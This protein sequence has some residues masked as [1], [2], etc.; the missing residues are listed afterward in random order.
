LAPICLHGREE[1]IHDNF[2]MTLP[3]LAQQTLQAFCIYLP[4]PKTV[5]AKRRIVRK[6]LQANIFAY[7]AHYV[8]LPKI[9]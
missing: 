1:K 8:H 2:W 3:G 7:C 6:I 9:D 4:H 5:R